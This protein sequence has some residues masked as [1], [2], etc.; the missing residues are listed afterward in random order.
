MTDYYIYQDRFRCIGCRACELHCKTEKDVPVGAALCK[1]IPVGPKEVRGVP[2]IEYVFMPCFQCEEAWC[3]AACPTGA[4]SRREKDGIVSIEEA[5]CIG[6]KACITA[7]PWGACQWDTER[8]KA[9]K[10]DYCKDR[11]D[12]GL[13]PACVTGCVT[14]ALKWVSPGASSTARRE[15]FASKIA[16]GTPR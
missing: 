12:A 1:I 14:K 3:M 4:M 16:K 8:G 6:C 2:R 15:R 11:L 5:R 7:C 9:Y 10:C 13:E